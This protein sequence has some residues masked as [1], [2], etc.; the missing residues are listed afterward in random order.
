MVSRV[1]RPTIYKPTLGFWARIIGP[2][3]ASIPA[4]MATFIVSGLMH[5]LIFFYWCRVR[6]TW[7]PML[8]FVLHG[9]CLAVEIV[10]KKLVGTT[11]N[12]TWR[13]PRWISGPLT[14]GFVMESCFR[15]MFPH[16]LRCKTDL[17]L[18]GEY[19]AIRDFFKTI[20]AGLA[21]A[22]VGLEVEPQFNEPYLST[23]LQDFWGRRW[24]LMVTRIL[25]HTVYQP[26]IGLIST[27]MGRKW[28]SIPAIIATF[29][30]SGLVHELMYFYLS[31]VPPTWEV[32][33]FFVLHGI[34]LTVEIILKKAL[35]DTWRVPK[36]M[37]R[38]LTIGFV[39][40]TGFWL[41]FPQFLRCKADVKLVQEWNL[42]IRRILRPTIY[43]PTLNLVSPLVGRKWAP[44]PAILGTFVVSGLVHELIYYYI[45]RVTPT[46]EV[47]SFFILHGLCYTIEICLKKTLIDKWPIPKPIVKLEEQP[48]EHPWYLP[49]DWWYKL[50]V[51]AGLHPSDGCMGFGVVI[52]RAILDET[53]LV[54]VATLARAM[55]G[56]ELE[57]HFNEPYLSTSLQDFWGK[58][59]NL[60]VTRI[61][62]PTVF[63]PT[64]RF[65]STFLGYKWAPLP[66]IVA[67]FVVSGL[68]HELMYFY[69]SRATP[70]WEVTS[71]FVLHGLCLT[72]EIVL[73]KGLCDTWRLPG[74]VSGALTMGFVM[75]TSF[76]LYFPQLIR[77]KADVK[78]IVTI[79]IGDK[80]PMMMAK[81]SNQSPN[82]AIF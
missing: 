36:V 37:S 30:V 69:V 53:T 26:T 35:G 15:L 60:I 50:N 61:L 22:V 54:I 67:T 76:W 59:W 9:T 5:E 57:P 51:D 45:A 75:L 81:D 29:L 3:W 6:P 33:C 4:I 21:R 47:T 46:W 13:L 31:R 14:V 11:T 65:S 43:E 12:D 55:V 80:I 16:V 19:D 64:Y 48:P 10:L 78:E 77:C 25:R 63:L 28:A 34:C 79:Q 74:V 71:F 44:I 20:T 82:M 8:F 27:L 68:V 7:E 32:T 72:V 70:T 49:I 66:A 18:F 1:L 38:M 23:S 41:F 42:M 52:R 73:K 62:R 2:K 56:L 58:R 17:R 24:N 40:L 39:M